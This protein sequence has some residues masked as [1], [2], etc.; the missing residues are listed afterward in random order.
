MLN[1]DPP[2]DT[3]VYSPMTTRLAQL[4]VVD[5]L[6]TGVAM[7]RGPDIAE[8]FER[9]KETVSDQWLADDDRQCAPQGERRR[10]G[11]RTNK[12]GQ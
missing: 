11:S 2:E 8:E 9:I 6:A 4:A 7:R 1:V 3:F 12:G 10:Q 5:V